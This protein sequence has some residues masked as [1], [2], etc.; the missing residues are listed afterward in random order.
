MVVS[1]VELVMSRRQI[2]EMIMTDVFSVTL[3][4]RTKIDQP[5]GGWKWSEYAS[6]APQDVRLI[7]FKRRVTEFLVNTE[8]GDI[9]DLPYILLGFHDMDAKRGDRFTYRGD[10]FELITEDIGE[11]EVKCLF[12]VDYYG[13]GINA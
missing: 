5:S 13:G 6:L 9:P 2:R 1:G 8:I 4:R 10:E 3:R 11:P 7:P 12:Q